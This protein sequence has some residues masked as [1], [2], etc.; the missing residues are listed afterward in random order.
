MISI[1]IPARDEEK[2]IGYCINSIK[3]QDY[4][5]Y[6]IIVVCN[7]CRDNTHNIAKKYTKK[8]YNIKKGSVSAAR[9]YGAKKANG[10]ILVFLDADSIVTKTLLLKVENAIKKG[11]VGGICETWPIEKSFRSNILWFLDNY[12]IKTFYPMPGGLTFCRKDV[13]PGYD[14][15][16]KIAEDTYMI[17]NLKKKGKIKFLRNAYVRT[18]MRRHEKLGYFNVV[19]RQSFG[20]LYTKKQK[21]EIVR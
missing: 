7:A 12:V 18:S 19:M 21:Y 16:L 1:I 9:N 5:D 14:E 11:Y 15:H 13:F 8:V 17:S 6:E 3:N 20:L 10:D 2:Y 4:K